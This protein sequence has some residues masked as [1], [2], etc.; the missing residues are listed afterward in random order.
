MLNLSR[1]YDVDVEY[2]GDMV[3][4][5]FTGRILRRSDISD[6]LHMLELTGTINFEIEGRRIIVMP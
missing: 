2:R 3:D 5:E 4:K 6:V 1:W